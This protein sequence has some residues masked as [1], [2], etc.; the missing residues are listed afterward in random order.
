MKSPRGVKKLRRILLSYSNYSYV[1][2]ISFNEV[3]F[4]IFV[5]FLKTLKK[6][7]PLSKIYHVVLE[8]QN[9]ENTLPLFSQI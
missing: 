8:K 7:F 2:L 4:W 5:W 9:R 1:S 6:S 3:L